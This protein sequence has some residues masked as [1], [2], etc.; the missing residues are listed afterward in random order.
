[1]L[2]MSLGTIYRQYGHPTSPKPL[3][4]T[5]PMILPLAK[6]FIGRMRSHDEQL[7]RMTW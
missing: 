7:Q 4:N 6:R 1:M 5:A 3:Y 2:V